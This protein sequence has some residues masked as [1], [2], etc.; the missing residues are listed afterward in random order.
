MIS[1]QYFK[2]NL[3]PKGL[4]NTA[5]KVLY[6]IYENAYIQGK[7][8]AVNEIIRNYKDRKIK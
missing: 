6:L 7:I 5:I 3:C 1:F 4:D 8:D 2:E